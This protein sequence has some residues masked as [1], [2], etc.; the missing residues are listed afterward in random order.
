MVVAA[1]GHGEI[2]F[3]SLFNFR[4]K[5]IFYFTFG[6]VPMIVGAALAHGEIQF[7]LLSEFPLI[8]NFSLFFFSL[9]VLF[10]S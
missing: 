9:L 8:L 3:H 1:L 2:H 6:Y 7:K 10:R 5:L 4:L